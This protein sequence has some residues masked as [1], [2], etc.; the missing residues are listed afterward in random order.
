MSYSVPNY[1]LDPQ[2]PI[3]VHLVGCGGTGSQLLPHLARIDHALLA[4]DHPGLH[5]TAFDPD[6]IS[7]ANIGRQLF[8][9]VDVGA[10][11]AVV[12]TTRVNRFFGLQWEAV[13][14]E[15]EPQDGD[16][17]NIVITCTD[18]AKSRIKISR[19]LV[20]R[21]GY[22]QPYEKHYFWLDVGNTRTTGQV[23]LGTVGEASGLPTICDL[24]PDLIEQD[25]EQVQGPSCSLAQAL[26]SQDLMVNTLMAGYAAD[27]L[28]K[29]FRQP[30]LEYHGLFVNLETFKTNP[31][32][33]QEAA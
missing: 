23:V 9:P 33:I 27:L 17:A 14:F 13:P 3:T 8:A 7:E 15:Y 5:V 21:P 25:Q 28:W 4:L 18:S 16:G 12:M 10:N 30:V 11:K 32:K 22:N 29:I 1:L 24:F 2:H 19:L 26:N 6:G 20:D 31:I